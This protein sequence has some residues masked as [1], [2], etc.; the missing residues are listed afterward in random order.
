MKFKQIGLL[1][2][3]LMIGVATMAQKPKAADL[4]S[5]NLPAEL[6]QQLNGATKQEDKMKANKELIDA[7]TSVYQSQSGDSQKKLTATFNALVKAKKTGDVAT[8]IGHLNDFYSMPMG[9]ANMD[10]WVACMEM[11][12]KKGKNTKRMLDFA[13][14]ASQLAKDRTLCKFQS[15]LWQAQAGCS[16]TLE[17]KGQDILVRFDKPIELYY[18][19]K[20]DNG[21]IYGT[22]G[23][24][25]YNDNKWHGK[26]GRLNWDRT[27]LPTTV[28][29][30]VLNNYT[31]ETKSPKFSADSVK[32]TN[33]NYF[34]SPILGH[35]DDVLSTKKDP[36]KY[37]YP[38]FKS[39]QKDFKI[40]DIVQGVDYEGTF[41]MNGGKMVTN[42]EENPGTLVFYRGGK[43]FIT[44]TAAKFSVT[45]SR[46]TVERASVVIRIASDSIIN[47]GVT[48]RYQTSDK[49]VNTINEP[50]RNF[51]SPYTDSYHNI[52]IFSDN[53]SWKVDDATLHFGALGNAG[54]ASFCT[55]ESANYYSFDKAR[56]M[57]G[58][59]AVNPA[60]LVYNYAKKRG[61][62]GEFYVEDLARAIHMDIMQVKLMIHT[63]AK[64]GLVRYNE[65]T[66]RVTCKPKLED[67]VKAVNQVK[68][69]DYDAIVL[70]SSSK[71]GNATLD[72][73]SND[74]H[75]K[76]V[77]KFVVSDSQRVAI[78]PKKGELVLHKNRDM[79]FS[80]RIAAGRFVMYVTD[81]QFSYDKFNLDLPKVDSL[82]FRVKMFDDPDHERF[83]RT[84][85]RDLVAEIQID[86]PD[87]HNGLKSLKGFPVLTSKE[88][89]YVYYEVPD[90]QHGAYKRD[91]FYFTLDPFVVKDLD[92]FETDSLWFGGVLTS[93]GIF[94]DFRE[95]LR[96]Q[97]DY[98]L[99]F[100][101]ETP[102]EGF[103]AY[104]GKGRFTSTIDLSY[105]GLHGR[106]TLNYLTSVTK[107]KT[108]LFLPDSMF[109]VTDTFYV[110]EEQ[111][112]PEIHNGKTVERWFPYKD[113]MQVA[114]MRGGTPF[115]MYNGATTLT[116]YVALRP[117]GAVASGKA[118]VEEDGTLESPLFTLN[119]TEMDA[120]VSTFTLRSKIYNKVAFH[121]ENMQ[122]HVDYKNRHA[123]FTA[124]DAI[125]RTELPVLQYMA[126]INK[127][128]WQMDKQALD[129]LDSHSEDSQG[130]ENVALRD[131]VG[132]KM[133]GA[134]FV[135]TNPKQDSLQFMAVRGSYLYDQAQLTARQV[136]MVEVADV[137][138]APAGDTLHISANAE[139]KVIQQSRIIASRGTK[140]H[141]FYD[142]DVIV[143][144]RNAYS[145][146]G[147]ID[148]VDAEEKHQ[149][150]F[151]ES[152]A[153]DKK[154][155]TIGNGFIDDKQNFTL[156]KA[157]GYAGK[158]RVQAD[159][160]AYYLD[161][162]VRL[163]HNCLPAEQ[164]GLLAFKGFID[165]QNVQVE[166]PELPIDWKGNRIT[167]GILFEKSTMEPR[168]AFLTNE[169]AVD[170]DILTSWGYLD[171]DIKNQTYRIASREKLENPSTVDRLLS[172]NTATCI[173]KGEGPIRLGIRQGVGGNFAYGNMTLDPKHTD[174]TEINTVFGVSFPMD[175]SVL[176]AL[177]QLLADD[178][179]LSP[180]NPDNDLLRQAMTFYL[181]EEKGNDAY[182]NYVSSGAFDNKLQ[183]KEFAQTFLFEKIKWQYSPALGYYYDGFAPLAQIGS[184]Q[185]HL[186]M[187]IKTQIFK[188]GA[189]VIFN[190]YMQVA[191]DT[192]FYF[193]YNAD[194]QQLVIYSSVGEWV[195]M[196]KALPADKRQQSDRTGTFFYR[197]GNN[198]NEVSN[199]LA[200]FG[201][202][203]GTTETTEEDE[204]E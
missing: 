26:G 35:V 144:G 79:S 162:G 100:V 27:G 148:F 66:Q 120:R 140:Y 2:M 134:R 166:V 117:A 99:G 110:R 150:I 71:G 158:V 196:V 22:T 133:P 164:M 84:P 34:K 139:M 29:W 147:Y 82:F 204:E 81:G 64:S 138:I 122:A 156:N 54:D 157:L 169:R 125:G 137:A 92:D 128:S 57:Q 136:F 52:D 192:W 194:K 20:N 43:K 181:G 149:K 4:T 93:A 182:S 189:D 143:S 200:K 98:S 131:R 61:F 18:G 50:Q 97:P 30:A 187:R 73:E 165:P 48:L 174:N 186:D 23:V 116:G 5:E 108:M 88:K 155:M 142:A 89:S 159:T 129:L 175:E 102:K 63:I 153:P 19:S 173:L 170:N 114:Q 69:H 3:A 55:F 104:G 42:D 199:F 56:A 6:L 65:G 67:Y 49:I 28:C 77:E 123:D 53:I 132:K 68:T 8:I 90:M 41:M 154:G 44:A 60:V 10:G 13:E 32:F 112:F 38:Q 202:N 119:S 37:T 191:S 58:I 16:F 127:F 11:L 83:V 21:T 172:L 85:L 9:K 33:T 106:G 185:L 1:A 14:W 115:S 17:C 74:L 80:G 176:N 87:N 62:E 201:Q 146:K 198:R 178:L 184:R 118:T 195:D 107:S 193:N 24:Y 72:L 12:Q 145:A 86:Q 70:E 75:I 76:G 39:Y 91:N 94:P 7:F 40:K 111:G 126:F 113:S 151:M 167:A 177:A 141:E 15:N 25:D 36:D 109:A 179:R 171:Y 31:A 59:D 121:A 124:N 130:M 103:P 203:D 180:T 101:R 188:R 168:S 152:I 78:Y 51:Y 163:L 135:S 95:P 190:L 46:L 160:N 161:G 96:V 45:P 47:D 197:I 183:P 105:H